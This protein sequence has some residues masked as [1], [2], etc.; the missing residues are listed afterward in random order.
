MQSSK[1]D[2]EIGRNSKS[3]KIKNGNDLG[4]E[5]FSNEDESIVIYVTEEINE[6]LEALAKLGIICR[7]IGARFERKKILEWIDNAWRTPHILKYLPQGFFA[8]IFATEEER[9][10]ILQG[11]VWRMD[12][13]PLYIQKW[14]HN[15]NPFDPYDSPVWIRLYGLLVEY[16]TKD[17]LEKI[18]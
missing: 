14:H 17:A 4:A 5:D 10:R 3:E 16:W 9:T 12:S 6:E 7:F 18:G 1:D 13:M 2:H 11:G 8:I 15:F